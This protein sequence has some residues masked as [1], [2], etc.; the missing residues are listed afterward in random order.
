MNG[1]RFVGNGNITTDVLGS[2]GHS[3]KRRMM[4]VNSKRRISPGSTASLQSNAGL[5][6]SCDPVAGVIPYPSDSRYTGSPGLVGK[7]RNRGI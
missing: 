7:R 4:L 3:M 1:V 2:R 6:E 5:A